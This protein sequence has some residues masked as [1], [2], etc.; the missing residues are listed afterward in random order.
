MKENQRPLQGIFGISISI[1]REPI[2]SLSC[3]KQVPIRSLTSQGSLEIR[4]TPASILSYPSILL[5]IRLSRFD[6]SR[7]VSKSPSLCCSDK[8][9]LLS[10]RV[11]KAPVIETS[12]V[13]KSCEIELNNAEWSFLSDAE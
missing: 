11:V 4:N 13:F 1:L 2:L 12:G 6:S 7:A 9:D 10:K 3:P 8:L 5:T